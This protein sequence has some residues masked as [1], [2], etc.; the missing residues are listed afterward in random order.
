M[1]KQLFAEP[2]F[3]NPNLGL[4][5]EQGGAPNSTIMVIN[6]QINGIPYEDRV[7]IRVYFSESNECPVERLNIRL[8]L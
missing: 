7:K 3:G 4:N 1:K 8:N 6:D 5:D 2:Y